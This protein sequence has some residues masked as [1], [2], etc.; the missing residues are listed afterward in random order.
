MNFLW[1][2]AMEERDT[3]LG[4]GTLTIAVLGEISFEEASVAEALVVART[5]GR[6]DDKP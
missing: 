2:G 1:F 3:A 4:C 6:V 5:G